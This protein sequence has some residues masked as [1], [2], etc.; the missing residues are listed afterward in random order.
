MTETVEEF[1][2]RGGE[3]QQLEPNER[4][5]DDYRALNRARRQKEEDDAYT[6]HS[7]RQAENETHCRK[8]Y[9]D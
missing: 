4:K 5:Y 1:L 7:M 3:V 6:D 9:Y 2:A 8:P